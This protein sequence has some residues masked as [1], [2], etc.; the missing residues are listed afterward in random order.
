[1]DYE[2]GHKNI[3]GRL[4]VLEWKV[5]NST[6]YSDFQSHFFFVKIG[7]ILQNFFFIEK[8]KNGRPTFIGDIFG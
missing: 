3:F 7:R 4:V 5:E 6:T 2:N 8:Y 1:M